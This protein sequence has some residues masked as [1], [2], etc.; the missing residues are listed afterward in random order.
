[1]NEVCQ[2]KGQFE[3]RFNGWTN[4]V[5]PTDSS[6]TGLTDGRSLCQSNWQFEYRFTGWTKSV[7]PTDSS[8]T[9][10]PDGRSLSVQVTVR[11]PV[12]RMDEVCQSRWQV[13]YQFNGWI[14]SVSGHVT[15]R[16]PVWRMDK[17]CN[18]LSDSSSNGST[19]ERIAKFF[20]I[21]NLA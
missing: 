5:S 21:S 14:K 3:Y 9:G 16:I 1:M 2:S 15:V 12:Y 13:E 18:S 19:V 6:N 11:I 17:V 7:S 10:L 4:S 8:N 20:D